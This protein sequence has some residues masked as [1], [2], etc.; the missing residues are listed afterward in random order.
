MN[1]TD[2]SSE[3]SLSQGN[4][5]TDGSLSN[6]LREVHE[7][8]R[9]RFGIHPY[10]IFFDSGLALIVLM[11]VLY[12]EWL[13]QIQWVRFLSAF[14]FTTVTFELVYLRAKRVLFGIDSRSYLQDLLAYVLPVWIGMAVW[15]GVDFHATI[16]LIGLHLPVLVGFIRVG[17]FLGGCCYGVPWE[18]G[19]R[20]PRTVFR[21]HE[22]S[23]Q[24]FSPG[25]DPGCRVFPIQ[26]VEA[27]FNFLLFGGLLWRVNEVGITGR[28]LPLYLLGYTGYR[29]LSDFFR[30]SS[31][32]P[33]WGP[34]SEAQW[35]SLL[36]F[37][38]VSIGLGVHSGLVVLTV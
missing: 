19:V 35:V 22:G 3:S 24:S 34:L 26:L 32:R 27:A 7:Y 29:F 33:D 21:S 18:H 13:A 17:C 10:H 38:T 12:S 25:D 9:Q 15:L 14:V 1:T 31:A 16:D 11:T 20:Y 5:V 30:M 23:C 28:T 4:Q 37:T 8:T 36:T 2:D 6:M